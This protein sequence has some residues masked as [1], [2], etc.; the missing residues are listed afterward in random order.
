MQGPGQAVVAHQ[1]GVFDAVQQ[2]VHHAQQVGH[3]LFLGA[4]QGVGLEGLSVLDGPLLLLHVLVGFHQEAAG[5]RGRVVDHLADLGVHPLDHEAHHGAGGVELAVGAGRVA[6]LA[7][8]ALIQV[9]QGVDVV[10]D[11]KV[12]AVDQVDHVAQ[13][14]AAEHTVVGLAEDGGHDVALVALLGAHQPAQVWEQV[15][16]HEIQQIVAGAA[17]VLVG[18]PVAPAI[19]SL[20]HVAV[21]APQQQAA[22]LQVVKTLEEQNPRQLW[23]AVHIGTEASVLAHDVAGGFDGR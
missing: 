6:H 12:D 8:H 2:Q 22:L 9:R 14:V 10:A 4:V 7:Q 3:G 20:D 11:V 16:V 1:V 18:G 21:P 23:D 17:P 19:W 13:Q 5:A 15:V